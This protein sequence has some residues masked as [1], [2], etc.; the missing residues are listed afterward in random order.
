MRENGS[1]EP[2]RTGLWVTI[3]SLIFVLG[4]LIIVLSGVLIALKYRKEK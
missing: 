2:L 3:W 4:L 1:C